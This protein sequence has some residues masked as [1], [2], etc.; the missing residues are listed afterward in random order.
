MSDTF[1]PGVA[2]MRARG[3]RVSVDRYADGKAGH[4]Q[5]LKM[6]GQKVRDG[7]HDVDVIGWAG[8]TLRAAG[9]DGRDGA[10]VRDQ[11]TAILDALRAQTV[12]A[13]DPA[14]SE[15]IQSASAT[16]CLT[17]RLCM[18]I[19]DCDGMVVALA[20]ATLGIGIP[21]MIVKEDYGGDHQSHVLIAC[22]DE[23]DEWFFADPSTRDPVG[24]KS[25]Y[26]VM[27]TWVNP[28]DDKQTEIVG[29]GAALAVRQD[30]DEH[31]R[32]ATAGLGDADVQGGVT[33]PGTWSPI[34]GNAVSAGL[35]Y[36]LGVVAPGA[37]PAAGET[38]PFPWTIDDARAFFGPDWLIETLQPGGVSG[39]QSSWVMTGLARHDMALVDGGNVAYSAVLVESPAAAQAPP[40]QPQPNPP[41]PPPPGGGVSV[42]Y[43]FLWGLGVA[44]VTGI[45]YGAWLYYKKH[46]HHLLPMG[47]R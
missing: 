23:S 8:E 30:G 38:G 47:H 3:I 9:L 28:L 22:R 5:S 44:A 42:A 41:Q 6:I 16:L 1:R 27:R 13:P 7:M 32:E 37:V 43:V 24:T 45:G 31:Y 25:K 4:D 11:V 19:S 33:I 15:Y 10:R 34:Q 26:V 18:P 36:A 29:I 46:G 21:T 35:R 12:Y 20:S 39:G 17:P 40:P 2:R 14:G